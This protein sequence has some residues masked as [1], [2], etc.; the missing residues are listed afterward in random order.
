[1]KK[2]LADYLKISPNDILEFKERGD[3]VNV[4]TVAMAKHV[5]VVAGLRK[6]RRAPKKAATK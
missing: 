3:V 6:K 5:V 2:Q 4:I 1:M